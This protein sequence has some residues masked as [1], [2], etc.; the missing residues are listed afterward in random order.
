M[1][2]IKPALSKKQSLKEWCIPTIATSPCHGILHIGWI[3]QKQESSIFFKR[4]IKR[5]N[6]FHTM[7]GHGKGRSEYVMLAETEGIKTIKTMNILTTQFFSSA[8]LQFQMIYGNC[9]ARIKCFYKILRG[10]R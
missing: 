6:C 10:G 2:S 4:L 5:T 8:F 7:F 3:H 9:P 1:V